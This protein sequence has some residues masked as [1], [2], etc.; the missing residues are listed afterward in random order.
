MNNPG[1]PPFAGSASD[2]MTLNVEALLQRQSD[3]WRLGRRLTVEELLFEANSVDSTQCDVDTL[4]SLICQEV[5]LRRSNEELCTLE[6]YRTRFPHL[7]EELKIQWEID[8]LLRSSSIEARDMTLET[9]NVSHDTAISNGNRQSTLLPSSIGRYE[10]VGEVGRGGIGV[11]Y[12]AWDPKLKRR[13]ALK[14]LKAGVDATAEE[15]LRIRAEAEAIAKLHHPNIVQIYDVGEDGWPYFAMEFCSGRSLDKRLAGQP[16]D[17]RVAAELVRKISL[18]IAVAHDQ[19][20]IHRDLKPANVL[21][22]GEYDWSPK[23]VDFG[24][25]KFLDGDSS[26]TASGS[27]LGTPAYMAP[28]QAFGDA[29]RVGESADIYSLG[30]ILYECLTGRPPFRGVTIGETLDQVRN[31]EPVRVRQLEPK[32]PLDLETITHTCLRKDVKQRYTRVADLIDDLGRFLDRK[33][34]AARRERW[35]ETGWRLAKRHPIAASLTSAIIGLLIMMTVGSLL[36]ANYTYQLWATIKEEKIAAKLGHADA[37]VGHAHGIRLSRHPGQRIESLKAIREAVR[38]GRELNQPNEWFANLRDEAIAAF[39]LPDLHVEHFREEADM[40]HYADYSDDHKSYAVMFAKGEVSLRRMEDHRE[41]ASIPRI[42]DSAGLGFIGNDLLL[43]IGNTNHKFEMWNVGEVPPSL[44]WAKAEGIQFFN[45]AVSQNLQHIAVADSKQLSMIVAKS[46]EILNS[47]P[48]RSQDKSSSIALHPTHPYVILHGYGEPEIEIRDWTNG[49]RIARYRREDNQQGFSG[50]AW[51]PDG[52]RLLLITGNGVFMVWFDFDP[53]H[54]K[55]SLVKTQATTT[56]GSGGGGPRIAF[57]QKGDRILLSGWDNMKKLLDSQSGLPLVSSIPLTTVASNFSRVDPLGSFFGF[58]R[59]MD[60][61]TQLGLL[62]VNGAR[63]INRPFGL[64]TESTAVFFSDPLGR[65]VTSW[66][67]NRFQFSDLVTRKLLLDLKL[68]GLSIQSITDGGQNSLL[69]NSADGVFRW[70]YSWDANGKSQQLRL[71]IPKRVFIPGG[72]HNLAASQDGQ[73]ILSSCMAG[74][75]TVEYAGAWIK[76]RMEPAGRKVLGFHTCDC[77]DVSLDGDRAVFAFEG[78]THLFDCKDEIKK[79]RV[80]PNSGRLVFRG[81]KNWLMAGNELWRTDE[82]K[83]VPQISEGIAEDLSLDARQFARCLPSGV[84]SLSDPITSNVFA[85]IE[86]ITPRFSPQGNLLLKRSKSGLELCDLK[87]IRSGVLELGLPW[88]GPNYENLNPE[89]PIQ[90][91]VLDPEL[92]GITSAEQLYRLIDEH[93]LKRAAENPKD[94]EMAFAAAMVEMEERNYPTALEHL[95]RVCGLMPESVTARQWRAYLLAEMKDWSAA[96]SDADWVLERIDEID[97]TILRIEWLIHAVQH[98]R[99]IAECNLLLERSEP[100]V[101]RVR[102]L[103][104][105]CYVAI[106]DNESAEKDRSDYFQKLGEIVRELN[107]GAFDKVGKDISLRHP[108]LAQL[109]VDKMRSITESFEPIEQDTIGMV[110]YRN[111]RYEEALHALEKN[112]DINNE[113]YLEALCTTAMCHA[114]LANTE[115]AQSFL[116]KSL[117]YEFPKDTSFN[118]IHDIR[119]LQKEAQQ[120]LDDV[121]LQVQ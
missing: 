115:K 49:E 86:G 42:D 6:E 81:V 121:R 83:I 52:K 72:T 13:V 104:S 100:V 51:S 105:L 118:T 66:K 20:I 87:A 76:T 61:P 15:L 119:L 109:L 21:L 99:A 44:L 50:A 25:A 31:R 92:R 43:Q 114:K 73:T 70:P 85:R 27:I 71:G 62:E 93:A 98:H 68:D 28:E 8:E 47:F 77:C 60:S 55:L 111:G 11:V 89:L 22:E 56:D 82:W 63:E 26:A 112:L 107:E 57:N 64:D 94:G 74:Y 23:V 2:K 4:L 7:V 80:L 17:P 32:V 33:P 36:F 79:V 59:S 113:C 30:A 10:I 48:I 78:K 12:E 102:G 16:L 90:E 75:T 41:I 54:R 84:I 37:L 34:I 108:L 91:I 88:N 5:S 29:K 46:G 9:M 101:N 106:G 35:Y 96:L 103:R 65:F 24:L 45:Y 18:G 67:H 58:V 116:Q 38:I 40:V 3:S 110:L 19:R 69:V 39:Q 97:F 14:R 117:L 120:L 1:K 53:E 95:H